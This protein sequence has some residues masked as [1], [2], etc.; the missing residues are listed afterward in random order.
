MTSLLLLSA[1]IAA[2]LVLILRLRLNPFLALM[3]VSFFLGLANGMPAQFALNSILKGAGDTLG[4]I[5]LIIVCGAAIGKL[6]EVL[7]ETN[8]GIAICDYQKFARNSVF[9]ERLPHQQRVS[10]IVFDQKKG[11]PPLARLI[12]TG[13]F[14]LG[15]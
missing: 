10:G 8:G 14:R 6:I 12:H 7:N 4:S 2:L 5:V 13:V 1:A 11:V 3:I 15:R 9:F